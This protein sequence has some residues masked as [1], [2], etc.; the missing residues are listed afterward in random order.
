M[1]RGIGVAEADLMIAAIG[2][3]RAL[4]LV[5]GDAKHFERVKGLRVED[6]L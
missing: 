6:W 3:A 1:A 5:T 4:V 2:L